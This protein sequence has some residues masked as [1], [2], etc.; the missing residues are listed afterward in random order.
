MSFAMWIVAGALVGIVVSLL[1]VR[2]RGGLARDVGLGV[3][4]AVVAGALFDL[5]MLPDRASVDV[6]GLVV[7]AAGGCAALVVYY[8]FFPRIRTG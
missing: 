1:V 7:T 5:V 6:F 4:G 2:A 3:A 8:T